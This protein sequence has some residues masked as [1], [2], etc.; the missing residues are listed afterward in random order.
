MAGECVC[1]G[2]NKVSNHLLKNSPT[3]SFPI[4]AFNHAVAVMKVS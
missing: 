4:D 2:N 1:V 3:N